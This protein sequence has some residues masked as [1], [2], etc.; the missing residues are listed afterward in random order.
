MRIGIGPLVS[1]GHVG[2]HRM[3]RSP[4][5]LAMMI[6][7]YLAAG[8]VVNLLVAAGCALWMPLSSLTDTHYS[9]VPSFAKRWTPQEWL[10]NPL[11][12][13]VRKWPQW[14]VEVREV[15]ALG[16][17]CTEIKGRLYLPPGATPGV[18]HD[19]V[20]VVRAGWPFS[21]LEAASEP[22]PDAWGGIP[23]VRVFSPMFSISRGTQ[24]KPRTVLDRDILIDLRAVPAGIVPLSPVWPALIAN[25]FVWALILAALVHGPRLVRGEFRMRRGCC[26]S[27]AY[28]IGIADCCTECGREL[29]GWV[30]KLR[31]DGSPRAAMSEHKPEG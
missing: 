2:P 5:K 21:C 27:C 23:L 11:D 3:K 15:H 12:W 25:T 13:R 6:L 8:A 30:L 22:A 14:D 26:R 1:L 10:D 9:S 20:L 31:G 28:P 4:L 24:P 17:R 18:G 29:P 19:T 16:V 7:A